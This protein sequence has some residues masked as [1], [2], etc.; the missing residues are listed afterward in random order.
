MSIAAGTLPA[1]A[2]P[3]APVTDKHTDERWYPYPP[4]PARLF[5]SVTWLIAGTNSKPWLA[6]WHGRT[7][8]A[9]CV[10]NLGPLARAK[11]TEGRDA[12]IDLGKDAAARLRDIKADTGTYLHD[13]GEALILWATEPAGTRHHVPFPEVPA[14]L[15][16]AMYDDEP[17]P[18]V[19]AQMADGW[20]QFV[21][22]FG[23]RP[24]DFL[25]CEMAVYDPDREIA[26][27]LD[28]IIVLN[29][30]GICGDPGTRCPLGAFCPGEGAHV[31]AM[32][33]GAVPVCI[34]FKTG[35]SPEGT[36]K[37]Q[38]AAYRRMPECRPDKTDDRLVPTPATRAGAVLHLRP[39][40]PGG[41]LL[42]LVSAG[43]DEEAWDRFLGSIDLLRGR[44]ACKDKPGTSIR[45]LR[46]DGTMPGPRLCDMASEGYGRALAPLRKALGA[47]CE[48][49]ALAEFTKA[50]VLAVKGVGPKFITTIRTLLADHGLYLRGEELTVVLNAVRESAEQEV[51]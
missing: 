16:D 44:Q 38:L 30:Y 43:D 14:H 3:L 6:R 9:W 36:W 13:I 42:Q 23:L 7:S 48:L 40:Y 41:Y 5:E 46:P 18:A 32:P 24:E 51:A 27:T 45:P 15:R 10:D 39:E 34:D 28:T 31:I 50:D 37:E 2:D 20:V 29:G 1:A 19:A 21:S 22:D 47:D 17:V 49:A 33:G 12:A 35:K 11:R 8:T 25:A 26:G 4:D